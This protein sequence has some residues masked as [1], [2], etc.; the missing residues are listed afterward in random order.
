[1]AAKVS[2][3]IQCA[4]PELASGQF[5]G[6]NDR[7]ADIHLDLRGMALMGRWAIGLRVG[8]LALLLAGGARAQD[9][10]NAVETPSNYYTDKD[11]TDCIKAQKPNIWKQLNV[12]P[13]TC[14]P[15]TMGQDAKGQ[16]TLK[17]AKLVAQQNGVCY[18][19]EAMNPPGQ[20]YIAYDMV[21]AASQQGFSCGASLVDPGCM[22]ICSRQPNATTTVPPT[23]QPTKGGGG[24]LTATASKDPCHPN[25]DLNTAAGRAAMQAN[26]AKD[27]AA[28]N[29][30]RCQHN[31]LLDVCKTVVS[32]AGNAAKSVLNAVC[33]LDDTLPPVLLPADEAA[34]LK[35][36][37]ANAKAML[38]K[39]KSFTDKAQWDAGTQ[40][41]AVK[42]FG[43]ASAATQK[44]VRAN[45]NGMLTLLNQMSMTNQ[46]FYPAR[47]E[48]ES[49]D[50]IA[51]VHKNQ[52]LS[53]PVVFLNTLYWI[54]PA[55][56]P[57]SQGTAIVHELSHYMPGGWTGDTVYGQG[58]CEGLALETDTWTALKAWHLPANP[59]TNASSFQYFVYYVSQQ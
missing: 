9:V 21:E 6:A 56:G 45:V 16:C 51:Y 7:V 15:Q 17:N 14:R 24:P 43:N 26:A 38:T 13:L 12:D 59:L 25:Y 33:P 50:S 2:L 37:L 54:Q 58:G 8:M 41:I 11:S 3:M 40:A 42:Y 32:V 36:A 28:C 57:D 53:H 44:T 46:S 27:A 29:E 31:P 30:F 52:P 19:C 49:E 23:T 5:G 22:A 55:T 4:F 20:I 47:D 34:K 35:A 10:F 1:M 39:T 48:G 18:Y